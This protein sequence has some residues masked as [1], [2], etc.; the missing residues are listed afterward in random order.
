MLLFWTFYSAKVLEKYIF[1]TITLIIINVSWAPNQHIRMISEGSCDT[2]DWS[3]DCWKFSFAITGINVL[4][5]KS[6][7]N[8]NNISHYYWFYHI[9]DQINAALVTYFMN[10]KKNLTDSKIPASDEKWFILY[11]VLTNLFS[12]LLVYGLQVLAMA[13]PGSIKFNQH[14]LLWI[15]HNLVKCVSNNNLWN[16][17]RDECQKT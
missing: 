6:Y 4:Q 11:T 16:H 7:L 2:E 12:K 17:I 5:Y 14:I 13:A 1:N 10:I 8:C 9:F 3:N 15:I